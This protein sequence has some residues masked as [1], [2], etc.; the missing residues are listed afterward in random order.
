MASFPDSPSGGGLKNWWGDPRRTPARWGGRGA[1]RYKFGRDTPLE[2]S[3][4]ISG[5]PRAT[6]TGNVALR[7]RA[8]RRVNFFKVQRLLVEHRF[9]ANTFELPRRD[10]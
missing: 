7:V 2:P 9:L 1:A 6:E 3:H 8:L 4:Y 5:Q 10:V